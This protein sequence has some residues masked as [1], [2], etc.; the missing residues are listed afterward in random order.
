PCAGN[1]LASKLPRGRARQ[2]IL[3]VAVRMTESWLLADM[4][5]IACFFAIP[6]GKLP[7][8]PDAEAHPKKSLVRLVQLYSP[9]SIRRDVVPLPGHSGL[10]GPLYEERLAEFVRTRWEPI[11]AAKKSPSLKRSLRAIDRFLGA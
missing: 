8:Q 11:K 4:A 2:F 1:L 6:E 9:D 7:R 3:R 10:T 5:Q